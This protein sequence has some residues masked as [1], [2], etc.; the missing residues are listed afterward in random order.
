ME[1][2]SNNHLISDNEI[3]RRNIEEASVGDQIRIKGWLASYG[4]MGGPTRGTSTTR[5]DAGN[6]ACETIFVDQ[7]AVL[8]SPFRPWRAGLWASVLVLLLSLTLHFAIPY[9]A[10]G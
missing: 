9:R 7:F 6:G 4:S 8:A 10:T 3:L 1:Q 2:L 5:T